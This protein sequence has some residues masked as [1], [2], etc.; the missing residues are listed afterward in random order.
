[1]GASR[2]QKSRDVL[3]YF[4][5]PRLGDAARYENGWKVASKEAIYLALK[6]LDGIDDRQVPRFGDEMKKSAPDV[7]LD[8]A[9][10]KHEEEISRKQ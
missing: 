7:E 2:R 6:V 5:S 3:E 1:V 10:L 4:G 8:E 9:S